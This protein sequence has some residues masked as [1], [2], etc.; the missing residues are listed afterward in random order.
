MNPKDALPIIQYIKDNPVPFNTSRADVVGVGFTQ[1]VGYTRDRRGNWKLSGYTE[2]HPE[3]FELLKNLA[4]KYI[5]DFKFTSVQLNENLKAKR[6]IDSINVGESIIVGFGDYTGGDLWIDGDTYSIKNRFVM[7]NGSEL[8]HETMPFK[9][10][11]YVAVFFNQSHP[12]P[13]KKIKDVNRPAKRIEDKIVCPKCGL[14]LWK[15]NLKRHIEFIHD[16]KFAKERERLK[17]LYGRGYLADSED[18]FSD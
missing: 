4:K 9:G 7:F 8:E 13:V 18:S 16:K 2:K 14:R 3:I 5:P 10:N 11:R 15:N 17:K 1:V 12:K 6:H